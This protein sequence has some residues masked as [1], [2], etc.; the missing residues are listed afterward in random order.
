MHFTA[1][2]QC[3]ARSGP[4]PAS[5]TASQTASPDEL[6][7]LLVRTV[8]LLERTVGLA[9][10]GTR[11]SFLAR[12]L[13]AEVERRGLVPVSE[14]LGRAEQGEAGA[15]LDLRNLVTVNY[16]C[17]WR[18]AAHWPILSEHLRLRFRAG[19]PVRLWSAACARGE[20]AYSMAMVAADVVLILAGIQT[21]WRI[22]ASDID[23]D[24]LSAAAPGLYSDAALGELPAA[25]RARYLM[26]VGSK[27]GPHWQV[28]P[29]L[30]SHI[31]FM[32]FDLAQ[33]VWTTPPGAPFDA[34]SLSNV[35]I[36]FDKPLQTRILE[37][38]ASCLRPDGI[39]LTS[40]SEGNLG[41]AGPRLKAC[42]DCAYILAPT[43]RRA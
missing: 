16:S 36:Y 41:L 22:L 3:A 38:A 1:D 26:S 39:L 20:E 27:G 9:A 4:V 6:S 11:Q 7:T 19:Q 35:L 8:Q 14:L 30:R 13:A 10:G 17:F 40:R 37:N 42:G 32:R 12:R 24:A 43:A 34:I 25:Q 5:Q 2:T 28:I 15:L 33:P 18:E 21:D 31:D 23:T 29:T